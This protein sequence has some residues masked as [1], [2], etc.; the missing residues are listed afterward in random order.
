[1]NFIKIIINSKLNLINND[2]KGI[3]II[4]HKT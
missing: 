2:L 1:M 4:I 3:P